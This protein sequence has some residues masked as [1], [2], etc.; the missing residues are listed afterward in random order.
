[1]VKQICIGVTALLLI[2]IF[3][4]NG[5]SYDNGFEK[6]TIERLARLETKVE[7]LQRQIDD[8]KTFM[9]WGFGIL[10]AGMMTLIGFVLWDRRT[11]LAPAIR[12]NKELEEREERIEKA[13]REYAK[14]E[15]G[16]AEVLKNLGLM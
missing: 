6:E 10:F 9:L 7:G 13:L 5:Y 11:A 14:K 2:F 16:L 3:V 12:K 1:M 4:N 15:P 8:I